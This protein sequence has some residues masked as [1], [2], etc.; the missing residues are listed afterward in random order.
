MTTTE[1]SQIVDVV[2]FVTSGQFLIAIVVALLASFAALV[3]WC[4]GKGRPF[5]TRKSCTLTCLTILFLATVSAS[6]GVFWLSSLSIPFWL[7]SAGLPFTVLGTK[8]EGFLPTDGGQRGALTQFLTSFMAVIA[9]VIALPL[10]WLTTRM[11]NDMI[12]WAQT[13]DGKYKSYS[14][15]TWSKLSRE[16]DILRSDLYMLLGNDD[17][18]QSGQVDALYEETRNTA[19]PRGKDRD[20]ALRRARDAFIQMRCLA[21]LWGYDVKR[22]PNRRTIRGVRKLFLRLRRRRPGKSQT[23]NVVENIREDA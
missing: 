17:A 20:Q 1:Q 9:L 22:S 6:V 10:K 13:I 19:V 5:Q 11:R 21:Y 2:A 18:A 14:S 16:A 3:T 4:N 8:V 23:S 12:Y 15:W 7:A